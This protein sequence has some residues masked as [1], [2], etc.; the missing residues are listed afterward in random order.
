MPKWGVSKGEYFFDKERNTIAKGLTSVKNMGTK[1]ANELYEMS[2]SRNYTRFVDVMADLEKY[3]SCNTRQLETLIKIDFFSKFGNQ[4][5]LLRL[6][7][8]FYKT[9]KRGNA[10]KIKKTIIDGSAL[11]PIVKK[12]SVGVKKSGGV[13]QSYTLLDV[14]SILRESEDALKAVNMPD[15][16]DIDKVKNF[17]EIM[18]YAGYVSGK[19]EDRRKLYVMDVFPVVRR[20]D[21][22]QFGYSVLAKSI[23]SGKETRYTVFNNVY[24][25]DPIKKDDII[26]CKGFS[27]DGQ[28]FQLTSYEKVF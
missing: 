2:H 9:F 22:K 1:I 3:T 21:G 5:E 28:Y 18:G 23:G 8:L 10:K 11:E 15:L 24:N 17:N 14:M 26:F 16:R 20:K 25:K 4:R 13:A 6:M 27:R 19:E 7:D 12:Y